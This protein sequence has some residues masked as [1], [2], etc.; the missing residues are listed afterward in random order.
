MFFC[1]GLPDLCSTSA[2][3]RMVLPTILSNAPGSTVSNTF[4]LKFQ[5]H[6]QLTVQHLNTLAVYPWSTVDMNH[7]ILK[8]DLAVTGIP[9]LTKRFLRFTA[10]PKQGAAGSPFF[11][12]SSSHSHINSHYAPL[13][14]AGYFSFYR[15][16]NLKS[17]RQIRD[18]T[19]TF[20]WSRPT[21]S[22]SPPIYSCKTP[23][24]GGG[25]IRYRHGGPRRLPPPLDRC[26]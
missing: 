21:P 18:L 23:I 10:H 14:I 17:A 5:H 3:T 8:P 6:V 25:G 13:P 1:F 22:T 24:C 15:T 12:C 19:E 4:W 26:T 11:F 2:S 20:L 9:Y 7:L 16:A